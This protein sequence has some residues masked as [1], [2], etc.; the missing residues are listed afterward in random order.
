MFT[1]PAGLWTP[2]SA[3]EHAADLLANI[4]SVLQANAVK[5][6][7]GN[8]IQ[9]AAS[10]GNIVWIL[11]LAEGNIRADDDLKL[12]AASQQF[13]VAQES[14]AQLA[15]TLPMT[16]TSYIPGA[17]SL[18]T[19][20]VTAD[21]SGATVP[22]G[23]AAALGTI[24][25]FVTQAALTLGSGSAGSVL[26]QADVLGPIAVA[27]GQIT[28]FNTTVPHVASVTNPLAAVLGRNVETPQQLRQ[29][30]LNGN[31]INTNIDGTRR[32][33]LGIQGITDARVYVN[34]SPTVNLVLQGPVNI[35]PLK[36][37]IVIAGSDIT[38]LAIA[39]AY[40]QRLLIDTFSVGPGPSYTRSDLTFNAAANSITTAA[41]NF[42]T[43]GFAANQWLTVVGSGSN[44]FTFQIG[45]VNASTIVG[46]LSSALFVNESA[47]AT[48]TLSVKN[49]QVYTTGSGQK[50][51][52]Q[53]DVATNQTVYVKVFYELGSAAATGFD[54]VIQ[55]T[56]AAIP[57][58]IGTPVTAAAIMQALAS[59]SF[60]RVT[61]A[62][63]SLD[64]VTFSN[65]VFVNGNSIAAILAAN[66]QVVAG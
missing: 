36:S 27:P 33:I 25:N 16:G 1:Y 45:S 12:L 64:N 52:V 59:Y 48:V 13:S 34:Q 29:R 5:D 18:L 50:I 55:S 66:V 6:S 3:S 32:A 37:Y 51:P 38:G 30:L 44:N 54:A 56:V 11:C 9:F 7:A 22:Q 47:G 39:S 17:Y 46:T 8:Q 57:W 23:T 60:A 19:L 65:E 62:Q 61:G 40:A 42:L 58:T 21:A 53:Y 49:V 41:G 2:K 43:A 15:E 35:P 26:C 28:A 4:N 63:V 14:D 31:V 24:C 10:L 20:V